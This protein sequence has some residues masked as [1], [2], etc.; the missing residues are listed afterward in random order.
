VD[1]FT[2]WVES[3]PEREQ[4]PIAS[5]AVI[6]EQSAHWREISDSKQRLIL[7]CGEQLEVDETAIAEA[8]RK[9]HHILVPV[10]SIAAQAAGALRLERIDRE[11]LQKVLLEIGLPEQEAYSFA[12]QSGGSFTVLR[13]RLSSVPIITTPR[14]AEGIERA[15]LAPLLLVGAW[16]DANTAD[17]EIINKLADKPYSDTRKRVTHWRSEPDS[18]VRLANGIWEFVSPLDAWSFLRFF[19]SSAQLNIFAQLAV[20]VLGIDDPRLDLPPGE[21]W[22]GP[23]RGK[24]LAHSSELRGGLA[25]TLA[26]LATRTEADQ[27][28]DTTSLQSRVNHIARRIL[29]EGSSWKRWA[30]LGYLL[31]VIAEAAPDAFLDAVDAALSGSEPELAKLFAEESGPVTGRAEHTGLLWALDR[32]AWSPKYL[33]RA[34]LALAKLAEHDPGGKW[35][36]RPKAS[37]RDIFFPGCLTPPPVLRS[38]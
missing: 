21:R 20:A 14:W 6:V 12:Q 16:N 34:S 9:G 26:L 31:P 17:Q 13:R 25:R 30:S 18:P 38:G 1:V 32:L 19:I 33:S 8:S 5:R 37:L 7:I 4:A 23:I 36:N 29:P 3:L 15:E 2:A 11:E 24:Q 28:D 35:A 22:L 10:S 27:A